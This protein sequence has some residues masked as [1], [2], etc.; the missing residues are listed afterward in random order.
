MHV[1]AI[2]FLQAT[3]MG[4]DIFQYTRQIFSRPYGQPPIGMFPSTILIIT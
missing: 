2:S 3:N 1:F 4:A